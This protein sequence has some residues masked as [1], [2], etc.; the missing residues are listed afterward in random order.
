MNRRE[1]LC[2]GVGAA[3]GAVGAIAE[4]PATAKPEAPITELKRIYRWEGPGNGWK[5][6]AWM[7]RRMYELAPGDLVCYFE[8]NDLP[9][10]GRVQSVPDRDAGQWGCMFL[11]V[12][13]DRL[14]PGVEP[15]R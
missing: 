2:Y 5:T 12:P 15:C 13:A 4:Q 9:V 14:P 6:A 10:Y 1:L 3:A 8:D 7:R 11:E